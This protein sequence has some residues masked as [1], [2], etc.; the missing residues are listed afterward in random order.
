ML[1]AQEARRREPRPRGRVAAAVDDDNLRARG[2]RRHRQDGREERLPAAGGAGG[3]GVPGVLTRVER[4]NRRQSVVTVADEQH[5]ARRA[6]GRPGDRQEVD[7]RDGL[8]RPRATVDLPGK[9][10]EAE[11][12]AGQGAVL[13]DHLDVLHLAAEEL[14]HL[15][16]RGRHVLRRGAG[17]DGG[18]AE[19]HDLDL[20]ADRLVLYLARRL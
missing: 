19:A 4:V 6:G 10:R 20:A 12:L 16:L 9:W 11:E 18:D 2:V 5:R 15:A 8:G 13:A 1:A 7:G 3:Y 14:Q 17:E